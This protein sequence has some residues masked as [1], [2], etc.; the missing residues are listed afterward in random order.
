MIGYKSFLLKFFIMCA[1]LPAGFRFKVKDPCCAQSSHHKGLT[2][3][4]FGLER[5][6]AQPKSSKKQPKK[7][8]SPSSV[9]KKRAPSS[10]IQHEQFMLDKKYN[11]VI[12]LLSPLPHRTLR[13]DLDLAFSYQMR[14]QF[15]QANAI[16]SSVLS[17]DPEQYEA[18]VGLGR[19]KLKSAE[20][21][22]EGIEHLKVAI[23]KKPKT[24]DAYGVLLTFYKNNKGHE[25]EARTLLNDMLQRFGAVE[26]LISDLCFHNYEAG[27]SNQAVEVC[28]QGTKKFKDRPENF[29]YLGLTYKVQGENQKAKTFLKKAGDRFPASELA[30]WAAGQF[31]FE[32]QNFQAAEKHFI[33]AVQSDPLSAR[34][35]MGLA[36][37]QFKLKKYGEA[38]QHFSQNCAL[39]KMVP[40]EFRTASGLLLQE[41][42]AFH[43]Q[44]VGEIN[45]CSSRLKKR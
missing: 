6:S 7:K 32:N 41:R 1:L 29:V 35:Q 9:I 37:S 28:L 44:Y 45:L 34:S 39:L 19:N 31:E 13:Q 26:S 24:K 15:D 14:Q 38:L 2:D 16:W 8:R 43:S 3:V 33:S 11:E 25:F 18:L 10:Q 30:Q 40:D 36:L 23:R 20:S 22:L 21:R 27:Y 4:I 42:S 17:R 12:Q 5:A